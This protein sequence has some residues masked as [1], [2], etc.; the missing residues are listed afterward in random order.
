MSSP[1]HLAQHVQRLAVLVAAG[2]SPPAAWAHVADADT[3]ADPVLSAVSTAVSRGVDV[4]TAIEQAT[5]A[6]AGGNAWRALGAA[7]R[8]A[9]TCGAPLAA[10][11]RAFAEAL[12]DREAARRDIEVAL[13]GPRATARIVMLLPLLALLLG[14]LMGVDLMAT[15]STPV[16]ATCI[17]AGALLIV[18]ARQW[19][20]RLLRAAEPRESSDGLALDLLAVAAF[21]GG[22]PEAAAGLVTAELERAG[23]S[24]DPGS[25]DG[26]VRLSRSTGAPLAELARTEAAEVRARERADARTRAERLAVRLMLP[27]GACVL[28][29]FL[30]LGVVP[31]LLG[32][33][34]S[35]ARVF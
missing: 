35:T 19:M 27:L 10:A 20:R 1:G 9:T 34:S 22:S 12:R 29:S 32:L 13:A 28:P 7:W 18:G 25:L 16:G 31:M 26:L 3:L 2:L 11:L 6:G 30:V 8:V 24:A 5:D 14:V 17:G 33:L 4:S 23:L 21:G 15:L